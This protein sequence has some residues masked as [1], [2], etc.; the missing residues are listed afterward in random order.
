MRKFCWRW[1]WLYAVL[2]TSC[3][4]Q[5]ELPEFGQAPAFIGIN[6]DGNLFAPQHLRGQ[7]WVAGFIFTRCPTICPRV[8]AEM[9]RW[10]RDTAGDSPPPALVSISVDP[11]HDGPA[12]MKAFG[13]RFGADFR[14]WHFV[15]GNSTALRRAVVEG[16]KIAVDSSRASGNPEQLLHGTHLV[17]VDRRG[18]IRGYYPSNE[19]AALEQLRKDARALSAR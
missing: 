8:T 2:A 10:A 13:E 15:T 6:Q 4:K 16:F 1:G 7:V 12:Q 9:S 5:A 11:E 18:T 14:R 19:S 3:G 17:L